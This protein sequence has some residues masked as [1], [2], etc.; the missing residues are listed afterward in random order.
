M[1]SYSANLGY[2]PSVEIEKRKPIS[3]SMTRN[4]APDAE[5]PKEICFLCHTSI[6]QNDPHRKES[7][8]GPYHDYC[9]SR[10]ALSVCSC[11]KKGPPPLRGTIRQIK[12]WVR[13]AEKYL[14][15]NGGNPK[16]KFLLKTI[17]L[18]IKR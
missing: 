16:L 6:T 17:Q 8:I 15:Q 18:Q 4:T 9:E 10:K 11:L 7:P 13:Y 5:A 2:R 12:N 14:S 1:N 3:K